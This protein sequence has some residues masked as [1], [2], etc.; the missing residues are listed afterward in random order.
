MFRTVT[1]WGRTGAALTALALA[2]LT[3]TP[4]AYAQTLGIYTFTGAAGNEPT[5]AV[6]A[7]PS[8]ASFGDMQRGSGIM[9]SAGANAFVATGWTTATAD[10][11]PNQWFGFTL[12]P[13]SSFALNLDSLVFAERRSLTG[14]RR[15][16][17]RSSIDNFTAVLD[18]LTV[19]DDNTFR[20]HAMALPAAFRNRSQAVEFRFYGYA[21]EAAGGSWRVDDVRLVGTVGT[22]G[23]AVPTVQF[24]AATQ[25]A[26]ESAG[27]VQVPVTL[28]NPGTTA[29]TVEVHMATNPGTATSGTDYTFS[30]QTLTFPAGSTTTQFATLSITDDT[31]QEPAETVV[32]QLMSVSTGGAIGV[33]ATMTVNITDND[34][35]TGPL[36]P[37]LS[38]ITAIKLNDAQGAATNVGTAVRVRGIIL[39]Q[40]LRATGYQSALQ[41]NT[42]GIGLFAPATST[43][44]FPTMSDSVELVGVISQ[45]RGLSQIVIDSFRV[46]V[47]NA[48]MPAPMVVTT[49]DEAAESKLVKL[50]G[51]FTLVDAAQWTAATGGFNVDITD[52]TN[53]FS[54]RI[55]PGA[56]TLLSAPVPTLPFR[57]TGIGAQ[58][59]PGNPPAPPFLS[60]YQITPR[61]L[62]DL[63]FVTGL[64]DEA[65]RAV[66]TLYPN[67]A[68][69]RLTLEAVAAGTATV[70][71]ATGR[72]VLTTKLATGTN[73]VAVSALRPGLYV[74][75]VGN[76]AQ[77]FAKQ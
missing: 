42:G 62:S 71:D 36:T 63:E 47:P 8:N 53:T 15:Y 18:S 30:T 26:A 39:S 51:P 66:F 55:S 13:N 44:T 32:L 31:Q 65:A 43:I 28:A 10:V 34:G 50:N 12:T 35:G 45:F 16:Q 24:G 70:L 41:D 23:P 19:P 77:R 22:G 46:L 3:T 59:V 56:A 67:P 27:T 38:T 76:A 25:N 49:L 6:D 1:S 17:V 40:N 20:K 68:T 29:T 61:N 52:G 11:D 58:F 74:V 54:M 5:F 14:P 33:P 64:T 75:R 9:P 60:G 48:P 72:V 37:P 57:V 2:A 7:Q 21:A 4:A 69:D 73:S